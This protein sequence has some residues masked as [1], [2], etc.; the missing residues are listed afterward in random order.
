MLSLGDGYITKND[1]PDDIQTL[2]DSF[3]Q[4]DFFDENDNLYFDKI[5]EFEV[6]VKLKPFIQLGLKNHEFFKMKKNE[7]IQ[8]V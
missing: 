5:N 8:N 3:P 1:I 7:R 6:F 2:L 4:L